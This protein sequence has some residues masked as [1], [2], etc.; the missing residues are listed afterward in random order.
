MKL[1]SVKGIGKARAE[2]YAKLGIDSAEALIAH[3]P[4]EYE[5]RGHIVPLSSAADGEKHA[6]LLTIATKPR[7][8]RIPGGRTLVRFRAYDESGSCEISYF[9]RTPQAIG[10]FEVG[11]TRRVWGRYVRFKG[12]I[13]VTNPVCEEINA[14]SRPAALVP[15]YK[16]S[17]NLSSKI[18]QSNV[19]NAL[20]SIDK[21]NVLFEGCIPSSLLLKRRIMPIY[22]AYCALHKPKSIEEIAE[23]RK[24]LAYRELFL[25]FSLLQRNRRQI[26]AATGTPIP[27]EFPT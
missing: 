27:V 2:A 24:S 26:E 22:D 6:C 17:G 10:H 16:L 9:C 20:E 14:K 25:Y 3:I 21:T 7:T 5:N 15:V 11:E 1:E 8:A 19:V 23:A 18:V 12:Q 13:T 4:R